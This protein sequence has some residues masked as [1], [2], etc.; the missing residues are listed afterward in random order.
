[1]TPITLGILSASPMCGRVTPPAF[2]LLHS[3]LTGIGINFTG[4][5]RLLTGALGDIKKQLR[6]HSIWCLEPLTGLHPLNFAYSQSSRRSSSNNRLELQQKVSIL[7]G[8]KS[9]MQLN[10]LRDKGKKTPPFLFRHFLNSN[11]KFAWWKSCW[12]SI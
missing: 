5:T 10:V 3:Y 7:S 6:Q 12:R 2:A 9:R 4:V 8:P 11:L 1:M